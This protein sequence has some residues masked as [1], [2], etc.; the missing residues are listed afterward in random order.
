MAD[1]L[2][3]PDEVCAY[4]KTNKDWL[5]DQVQAHHIPHIRLG[6][7]LRFRRTELDQFLHDHTSPA[8]EPPR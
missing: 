7:Q 8:P 6:R 3:T 2:M 1:E 5:Y 4:L